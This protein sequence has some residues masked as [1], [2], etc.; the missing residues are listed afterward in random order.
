M[1]SATSSL[2]SMLSWFDLGWSLLSDMVLG[3]W[4]EGNGRVENGML[5]R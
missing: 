4:N 2:I 1:P 5:D 3:T